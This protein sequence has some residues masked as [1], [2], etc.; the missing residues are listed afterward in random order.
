MKKTIFALLFLVILSTYGS[1]DKY[2]LI[3]TDNPATTIM[4]GWNQISGS[5]PVVYY[6][7]TDNG[8]NWSNYPNSKSVNRSVSYKGMNNN[9]AQLTGLTPNTNYYFVIKDSEGVSSRFWF[10]TAP[11]TNDK[12]SF[13]AGGDS[14]N[15]RTP[16]RDAN[17][18]VSKLK[19]TAVFFGGDMTNGDSNSEWQDWFN[20]WQ[21]TTA[22]DGRMFP[23]VP[24]RGNHEGSNNSIYNL[25]NVPSTSVYY[26]IT[27]GNNLYTIYTLNSEISAGGTQYS[28][29]SQKLNAN[30]SIWKSAQYHKPMRPHVSSKSEG[31]DEYSSWSQL[32]YDKGVNLVF[33]SDSH[34]VKTTWPVKPCSSGSNCD[35][36]FVRDDVNGTI[37]VGEGCWGAPLRSSDD[38]KNWTR[39]ASTFNQFKWIFVEESKIEVRTIKVDNASSVGA[40]SNQNPFTIPSNLDIWTPSNGSVVTITNNNVSYPEVTIT[41]PLSGSSHTVNS[42]VTIA[43]TATDSDGTISDVKFYVNNSLL[44][45]DSNT[46]YSYNWVPSVDN[47]SY[48]IKA[49]ATDNEGN[50]TTSEE[51]TVFVG[52][53]SKTVTS[54]INST[55]DDAEQY[56]SS[57]TMYMNSSDL[58]LVYDGS[59]KG[60]QHIGLL[61]RNL[62][63][64]ADATI[65]NAFIQFTTDETNSGSTS[66]AIKIQDSSNA[67]DITSQSYNITSRSYYSQSVSW[68]PNPWNSIGASGTNQRTPSLKTLVQYIVNKS[69]WSSGNSMMFYISGT[70][71]RTAESYDGSSSN[72]PKLVV[73]YST[74]S[75]DNG[76]G[77][78]IPSCEDLS[79]TITFDKYS[80]ETSWT[81]KNSNGETVLSGGNYTQGNGESVTVS[82]CLSVGCYDFTIKDE[83]GDGICCSYGSGS[84]E[85]TNSNGEVLAS[86]GSFGS[87]ETKQVCLNTSARIQL[88]KAQDETTK[89]SK[90]NIFPN[91]VFDRVYIRGGNNTV[92]WTAKIVDLSGRKLIEIP[93]INNSIDLS[94]IP[95]K[96]VYVLEIYDESGQKKLSEKI[97][98]K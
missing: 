84:Y 69:N 55:N 45:T 95:N 67:P 73:T 54:T 60:N 86:G 44:G 3:I 16:R 1:N 50:E 88:K 4:I 66:L 49:V 35:E 46:P 57:G 63:I 14:R 25:F 11:S 32:F 26:D 68:S 59:S 17:L 70:G 56:E 5:T 72:A 97:V 61:F 82:K 62:N 13:I 31:N 7:T 23:I 64:P 10:K 39:N 83:Y 58:E 52:N 41:S 85:I 29:L 40:V 18:L 37:Y 76:G 48:T 93:V 91:P 87:S 81:L 53:V 89:S 80:S 79:I 42:S 74:G 9:F 78:E 30:N 36:G 92:L 15:N 6:G 90:I 65:T 8:A 19:P 98:K 27:F 43:A 24:T 33:E 28:W 51:V 96:R 22:S 71:E 75:S 94:I 2:R 34:T 38:S 12:M 77:G 47:Q 20:D 21:Y